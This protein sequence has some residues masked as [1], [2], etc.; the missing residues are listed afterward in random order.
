MKISWSIAITSFLTCSPLLAQPA[1]QFTITDLG[2]LGSPVSINNKGHI[3]GNGGSF[4]SSGVEHGFIW[5]PETGVTD[6]GALLGASGRSDAVAMNDSDQVVGVSYVPYPHAIFW[7]AKK[8]ITDLG[9]GIFKSA[10]GAINN[11]GEVIGTSN[12]GLGNIRSFLW[13]EKTGFTDLGTNFASAINNRGDIVG[14]SGGHAFLWSA[15]KGFTDLGTLGGG[16]S[17]A[18]A[19]NDTGQVIGSSQTFSGVSHAFLWTANTGMI[20]LGTLGGA[21]GA[22]SINDRGD[23]VGTCGDSPNIRPFLWTAKTGMIGLG[24]LGGAIG[25]GRGINNR[26]EVV[27]SSTTASNFSRAFYWTARTGMI[28]LTTIVTGLPPNTV[29]TEPI[30]INNRGEITATTS[31]TSH[32][33]LLTPAD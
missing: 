9:A 13:S 7:T 27:G 28:D 12:D 25:Y 5:T 31:P 14:A 16:F 26:G 2:I 18:G 20:D 21:C 17:G 19:I 1:P 8:G 10:A 4:G 32:S 15:G 29:I 30:S 3:I 22:G 24:S 33:V 23:V 11:R 6:I